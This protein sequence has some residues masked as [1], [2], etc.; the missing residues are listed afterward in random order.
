MIPWIRLSLWLHRRLAR[1][2]PHEFQALHGRDLEQMGD[3][4]V[5][6]I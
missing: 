4:A 5:P 3:N 1:A 6:Y 2:F